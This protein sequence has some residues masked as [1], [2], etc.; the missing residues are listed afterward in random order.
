MAQQGLDNISRCS[1]FEPSGCRRVAKH[2]WVHAESDD[3]GQSLKELLG[4]V[5]SQ[6]FP[7]RRLVEVDENEV[8]AI[9]LGYF[10]SLEL[11][12]G[13]EV[14]D[15][16]SDRNRSGEAALARMLRVGAAAHVDVWALHRAAE[17]VVGG[18]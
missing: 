8:A 11:I 1:R 4:V 3:F 16:S 18:E 5:V 6:W 12:V 13:V 15:A 10:G 9:A 17:D 7:K 2:V 14:D